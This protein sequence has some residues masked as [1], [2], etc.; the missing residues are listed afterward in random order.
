MTRS[1]DRKVDWMGFDKRILFPFVS[2][3]TKH[4]L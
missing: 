4:I 2:P 3:H 1:K